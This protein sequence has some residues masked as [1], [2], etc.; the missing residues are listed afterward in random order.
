M[1]HVQDNAE[2]A[3]RA[4]LADLKGGAFA[5]A[6]DRGAVV[7]V[8][9]EVDR[10]AREAVV[11]F[12]GASPQRDDNFN[13]PFAVCRAA[14]LYVVRTL[15]DGDMPLNDGCLRPIRIVAPRRAQWCARARPPLWWR[16]MW[17]PPR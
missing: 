6:T 9:I 17:R 8:R 5:Y 12:T 7:Q 13:A 4:V 11:D 2:T 10:Q 3:V 14:V 1:G 16:A 15:L